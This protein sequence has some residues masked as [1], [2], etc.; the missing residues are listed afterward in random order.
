LSDEF[1]NQDNK[2]D[3][4]SVEKSSSKEDE[5]IDMNDEFSIIE[6]IVVH[7][8]DLKPKDN[9]EKP[10]VKLIIEHTKNSGLTIN[11]AKPLAIDSYPDKTTENK[12]ISTIPNLRHM[13]EQYGIKVQYNT[14][15][16]KLE[17]VM[18]GLVG[19][20]DNADNAALAYITSLVALNGINTSNLSAYLLAIAN[21]NQFNP[22]ADWV[23]SKPWDGKDRLHD[24]YDTI[25]VD[26]D[27]FHYFKP[28]L[29][30]KWLLSLVAAALMPF[31]FKARGVLVFQG[32]QSIGKTTWFYHLID[33]P[34]LRESLIKQDHHLDASNKDSL[35][36]ALSHWFV[37]I[38][39]LDSS[40]RKDVAR[41][42][43]FITSDKDKI[44]Q[45]YA[46]TA[47]EYQRR[48][49]F[50]A[51]VNQVNFLVDS[52]GNTRWWVIPVTKIDY[53]HDIDM[54]QVF[55]Q[56]AEDFHQGREWWLNSRDEV[57]LES[58]NKDFIV[59]NNVHERL[60]DVVDI[61]CSNREMKSLEALSA[62]ELLKKAGIK[63]PTNAQC[64]DCHHFMR[65]Q[66][67][68]P[69]KIKGSYKWRVAF[70]RDRDD[71]FPTLR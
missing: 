5:Y 42:K 34:L 24:L 9:I 35:L 49:V 65:E 64:K 32:P 11:D 18:P 63:N 10:K 3:I 57:M 21:T 19:S 38:G 25:T 28:I 47:S 16:K 20:P 62:T 67:G 61:E 7:Q 59:I 8:D 56:L 26:E 66:I 31:G 54:Q 30:Y 46:K 37:E 6:T 50:C 43:G 17:I 12:A 14:V 40:F 2:P 55:A 45:P 23:N 4:H 53:N 69:K 1:N 68:S 44:R 71:A 33:D 39:E 22:A 48:T 60:R 29:L 52:T 36:T 51:T 70:I 41:L 58:L 15:K 27:W 13:L